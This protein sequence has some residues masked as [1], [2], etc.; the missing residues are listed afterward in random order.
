MSPHSDRVLLAAIRETAAKQGEI[1]CIRYRTV[2][3]LA[4]DADAN[5][6]AKEI[7]ERELDRLEGPNGMADDDQ[8]PGLVQVACHPVLEAFMECAPYR[9]ERGFGLEFHR[10]YVGAELTI[11][12]HGEH[13][14]DDTNTD[15]PLKYEYQIMPLCRMYGRRLTSLW[16]IDG[17]PGTWR[18]REG[19]ATR[20]LIRELQKIAG[21]PLKMGGTS[22]PMLEIRSIKIGELSDG[23][24]VHGYTVLG[25]SDSLLLRLNAAEQELRAIDM[26]IVTMDSYRELAIAAKE[27][28]NQVLDSTETA[29][30]GR[31]FML[32]ETPRKL[33]AEMLK[34][35]AAEFFGDE[36]E[37]SDT[38]ISL[39]C[40]PYAWVVLKHTCEQVPSLHNLVLDF[41]PVA[42]SAWSTSICVA[43]SRPRQQRIRMKAAHRD[44]MDQSDALNKPKGQLKE[45]LFDPKKIQDAVMEKAFLDLWVDSIYTRLGPRLVTDIVAALE[46]RVTALV[47]AKVQEVLHK[48]L[49]DF[50]QDVIKRVLGTIDSAVDFSLDR[51]IQARAIDIAGADFEQSGAFDLSD[52]PDFGEDNDGTSDDEL[53]ETVLAGSDTFVSPTGS[54]PAHEHMVTDSADG[55]RDRDELEKIA[56]SAVDMVGRAT[57]GPLGAALRDKSNAGDDEDS[58]NQPP[59]KYRAGG[60]P[61]QQ[62]TDIRRWGT[63]QH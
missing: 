11:D 41:E 47:D 15:D 5:C 54:P 59:A 58:E 7:T 55:K 46:D 13:I 62:Q 16:G 14:L 37:S 10:Y 39:S 22:L 20:A 3:E 4:S 8:R 42:Q 40:H 44:R 18:Q 17:K 57:T 1:N 12:E 21:K 61:R 36:Y 33:T 63:G 25:C 53:D 24:P 45:I 27:A 49:A 19:V 30:L 2:V 43:I 23:S 56:R 31:K 48:K 32:W 50:E 9:D 34:N 6:L 35:V 26:A 38:A 28:G 29:T 60:T 52:I 51:A